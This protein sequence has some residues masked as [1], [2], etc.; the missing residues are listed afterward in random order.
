MTELVRSDIWAY[1]KNDR[2]KLREANNK[3]VK[4]KE[5]LLKKAKEIYRKDLWNQDADLVNANHELYQK[6]NS[7]LYKKDYEDKLT[8]SIDIALHYNDTLKNPAF[9]IWYKLNIIKD[10]INA[11]WSP[12]WE[13]DHADSSKFVAVWY[14]LETQ[15]YYLEHLYIE[16]FIGEKLYFKTEYDF[17]IFKEYVSDQEIIEYLT[18]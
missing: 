9:K 1:Y 17:E 16:D 13:R 3:E 11:N 15:T 14:N 5:I 18:M 12:D 8:F 4:T 10:V 6:I 7:L 2:A